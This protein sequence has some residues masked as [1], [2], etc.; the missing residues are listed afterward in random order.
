MDRGDLAN[1][2]A[3]I[4]VADQRSF[5]AAAA[6]LGVTPS[7]LSHSM[8][9]L[10]ERLGVRLLN[11]S[12]RSVS[13]SDAG[14]R[15]LE[16]ATAGNPTDRRCAGGFEPSA[17]LDLWA[18][19]RI[20]AVTPMAAAAVIASVW[21]SAFYRPTRRFILSSNSAR[22]P[23]I[24]WRRD[25]DAGVGPQDR[26]V[27]ADMVIVRVMGPMKVAVV[28]APSYFAKA[29]AAGRVARMI[30]PATPACNTA[31]VPMVPCSRGRSSGM[32]NRERFRWMAE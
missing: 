13:V 20:H 11:R 30:S 10:E 9:Q 6:R 21:Q 28:A 32:V 22:R 16:Q 5:R 29:C 26:G 4:A 3:F 24:S 23:S 8:R 27:A 31:A 15:L 19:W 14:H 18:G 1:L 17:R 7:A 2:T 12:T 25:L